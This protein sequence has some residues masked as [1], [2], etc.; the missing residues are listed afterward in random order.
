[1][2]PTL[3]DCTRG[4]GGVKKATDVFLRVVRRSA[5]QLRSLFRF[6]VKKDSFDHSMWAQKILLESRDPSKLSEVFALME[7]ASVFADSRSNSVADA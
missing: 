5:N 4:V 3:V 2:I 1:M 7:D 6:S